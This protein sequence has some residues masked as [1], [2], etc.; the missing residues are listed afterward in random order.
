MINSK[1]LLVFFFVNFDLNR[2]WGII[3]NTLICCCELKCHK[4]YEFMFI[5][6]YFCC[7]CDNSLEYVYHYY[8]RRK[9]DVLFCPLIVFEMYV[10]YNE[11]LL[12][13]LYFLRINEL[14]LFDEILTMVILCSICK[15]TIHYYNN[16]S[17]LFSLFIE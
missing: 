10:K 3:F 17:F 1:L 11:K 4:G 16:F 8:N 5:F 2:V 15:C 7:C 6:F 12:L 13:L 9:H 14:Y